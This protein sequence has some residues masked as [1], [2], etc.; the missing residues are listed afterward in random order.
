MSMDNWAITKTEL[1]ASRQGA[2]RGL[3]DER[4]DPAKRGRGEGIVWIFERESRSFMRCVPPA[5]LQNAAE[6]GANKNRFP[7]F[8]W[9]LSSLS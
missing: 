4:G 2:A 8:E 9:K 1:A 7:H 5:G 6:V 3:P